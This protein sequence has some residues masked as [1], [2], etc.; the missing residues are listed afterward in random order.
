[1]VK[2]TNNLKNYPN[3]FEPFIWVSGNEKTKGGCPGRLR[4]PPFCAATEYSDP[5][6]FYV[7]I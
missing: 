4:Q 6:R 5:A 2:I 1:L 3:R 7:V